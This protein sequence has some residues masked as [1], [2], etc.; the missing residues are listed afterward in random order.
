MSGLTAS[1]AA[2]AVFH[3]T[4]GKDRTGV[5]SALLLETLG[6]SRDQVVDDYSLTAHYRAVG[7]DSAGF[8]LMI[9]RGAPPEAVE[10]EAH[11]DS[12]RIRRLYE[13]W[14]TEGSLARADDQPA[15]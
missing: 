15:S 9:A 12:F 6:V 4:A 1:T 14:V 5:I 7:K 3:C 11:L 8:E 2:P 13:H 10:T